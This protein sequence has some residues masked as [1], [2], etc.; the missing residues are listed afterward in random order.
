M[1]KFVKSNFEFHGGYLTYDRKFV[2]R[3]KYRLGVKRADFTKFLIKNMD[4]ETYFS[5][6]E[7]GQTPL[8]TLISHGFDWRASVG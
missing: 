7:A 2:A 1:A 3:F 6:L 8:D 4:V 5:A